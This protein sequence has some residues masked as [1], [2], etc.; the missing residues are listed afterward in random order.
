MPNMKENSINYHNTKIGRIP[1]SWKLSKLSDLGQIIVSNVDKKVKEKEFP[2]NLCNYMDVYQNEYLS[3]KSTFMVGSATKTEIERYSLCKG[4]V[5][6][7]K[8]SET[9]R[10]IAS[11]TVIVDTIPNLICGYHLA[12]IRP[13]KSLIDGCYLSKAL[14]YRNIHKQFVI[15]ANGVTRFGLTLP[16]IKDAIMSVPPLNEQRKISEI[17]STW[18]QAIEKVQHLIE[19]KQKLKKGLTKNFI[20]GRIH[21][22]NFQNDWKQKSLGSFLQPIARKVEKPNKSYLRLGI[23]SHGKGTFTSIVDDP[24]TIDLTHLYQTRKNDLIVNI[25]FAWEGAIALVSPDGDGALVSHR[26][27]TYVFVTS[28]MLPEYFKHLMVTDRF[29]YE[30]VLISPG[31]AGR[32]RVMN[33]GDFLKIMVTIPGV[34]EQKKIAGM[35][36]GLDDQIDLLKKYLENLKEQ[37]KG[38]MEKLLTGEIRVKV[39]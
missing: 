38:L 31:G 10:D 23:R 14:Q 20:T 6:M 8:D 16:V 18:D 21:F 22:P 34:E 39:D 11:S 26:F 5:V 27:P 12:I 29:F 30:L 28:K 17:L 35:L 1:K 19:K 2:V 13:N 33:K 37:K 4:D 36:C 32:N 9:S 25:T 3:K 7:T 15:N 24:N